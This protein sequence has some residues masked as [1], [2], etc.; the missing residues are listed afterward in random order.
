M[1]TLNDPNTTNYYQDDNNGVLYNLVNSK[2]IDS[3]TVTFFN[4]QTFKEITEILNAEYTFKTN[5]NGSG[6]IA[7]TEAGSQK[8]VLNLYNSKKLLIQGAGSWEWR[9]TAF[10]DISRKLTPC[11]VENTQIN[12]GNTPNRPTPHIHLMLLYFQSSGVVCKPA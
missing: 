12:P 8:V 1:Q 9:N 11:N 7:T 6:T 4:E 2:N 10:R 3:F 5:S